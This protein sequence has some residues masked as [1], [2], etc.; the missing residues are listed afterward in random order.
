MEGKRA[1]K[2]GLRVFAQ[3]EMGVKSAGGFQ[4][5]QAICSPLTK[6]ENRPK[7]FANTACVGW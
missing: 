5:K 6:A 7:L 2:K 3:L 4:K 1:R